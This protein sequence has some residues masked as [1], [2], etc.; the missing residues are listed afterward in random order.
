MEEEQYEDES[1]K[2]F[3]RAWWENIV[4]LSMKVRTQLLIHRETTEDYD[5]DDAIAARDYIVNIGRLWLEL[6]PEVEGRTEIGKDLK[7]EFLKYRQYSARGS[8]FFTKDKD[9]KD[10]GYDEEKLFAM[11]ENL[12]KVLDKLGITGL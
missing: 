10:N 5:E 8:L 11:E 1:Y 12:R 7:A 4:A 3:I 9:G 6:L 2:A